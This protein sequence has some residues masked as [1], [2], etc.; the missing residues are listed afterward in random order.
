MS[1]CN[2]VF[3]TQ[4]I[5]CDHKSIKQFFALN[6][7]TEDGP[8]CANNVLAGFLKKLQDSHNPRSIKV[9]NPS[10]LLETTC[11]NMIDYLE[12]K[13]SVLDQG[14]TKHQDDGALLETEHDA[15]LGRCCIND[16]HENS[17]AAVARCD[18]LRFLPVYAMALSCAFV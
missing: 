12:E 10:A 2:T 14:L 7:C 1:I 11:R 3:E 8:K 13:N 6:Q 4:H 9:R 17:F 16:I 15:I 5:G 18:A